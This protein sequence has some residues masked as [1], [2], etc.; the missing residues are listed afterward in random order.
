MLEKDN[1]KNCKRQL[2]NPSFRTKNG[3]VWCDGEYQEFINQK[4]T[5]LLSYLFDKN[6]QFQKKIKELEIKID[7]MEIQPEDYHSG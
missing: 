5:S 2:P 6:E 3:C 4:P 7:N 1:C